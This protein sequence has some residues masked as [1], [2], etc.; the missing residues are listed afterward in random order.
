MTEK[1]DQELL[2][3][4]KRIE[5][6]LDYLASAVKEIALKNGK[7]PLPDVPTRPRPRS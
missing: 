4:I 2:D 1:Q 7:I 3:S 6:L 5:D